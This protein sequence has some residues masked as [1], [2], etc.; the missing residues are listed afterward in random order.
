MTDPKLLTEDSPEIP[1]DLTDRNLTLSEGKI[2]GQ[3]V[4]EEEE[5]LEEDEGAGPQL[6]TEDL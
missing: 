4:L 3:P 2:Q 6:L 1:R 5:I